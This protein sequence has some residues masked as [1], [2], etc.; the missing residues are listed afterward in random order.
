ML[1][2]MLGI[3]TALLLITL[4]IVK[5]FDSKNLAP[6]LAGSSILVALK[7]LSIPY[8]TTS[9][10]LAIIPITLIVILVDDILTNVRK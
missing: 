6:F 3:Y 5:R 1:I 8:K 2:P 4:P 7:L 9:F 10:F